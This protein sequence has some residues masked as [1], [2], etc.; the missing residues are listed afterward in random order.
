VPRPAVGNKNRLNILPGQ[1]QK[2]RFELFRYGKFYLHGRTMA[3]PDIAGQ[4]N[5]QGR[6]RVRLF[7]GIN[8]AWGYI[9]SPVPFILKTGSA[10]VTVQSRIAAIFSR[11]DVLNFPLFI[12]RLKF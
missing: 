7:Y 11:S 12:L 2:F 1:I 9:S 6:L 5:Q 10:W 8:V 4:I 3:V